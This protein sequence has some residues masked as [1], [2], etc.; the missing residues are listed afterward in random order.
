MYRRKQNKIK[1]KINQKEAYCYNNQNYQNYNYNYGSILSLIDL[2]IKEIYYMFLIIILKIYFNF[3]IKEFSHQGYLSFFSLDII[4]NGGAIY[5]IISSLIKFYDLYSPFNQEWSYLYIWVICSIQLLYF[6][7]SF[8]LFVIKLIYIK[9]YFIAKFRILFIILCIVAIIFNFSSL[10]DLNHDKYSFQIQNYEIKKLA[11]YKNYFKRHYVNLYLSKDYDVDEYELCFEMK[12]PK[13]F[14][15]MFTN[16]SPYSLWEFEQKKDYFIGCRNV[17]FK[18]N[19]SIDKNNPLSFFKCDTNEK[20]INVLPNYCIS[21]EQR[22]KKHNF[23]Y[24]LNIFEIIV[25]FGCFIYSKLANY[26]FHNHYFGNSVNTYQEKENSQV[27]EEDDEDNENEG[28]GEEEEDDEEYEEDEEEE[29]EEEEEI[30]EKIV[31]KNKYRKISKKKMKYYKKKQKNRFRKNIINNNKNENEN[32]L[33]QEKEKND[34][35]EDNGDNQEDEKTNLL[36][37]NNNN[38]TSNEN[39]NNKNDKKDDDKKD[40][41]DKNDDQKENDKN[42]E[43]KENNRNEEN[44]SENENE[45]EVVNKDEDNNNNNIIKKSYKKN[46]FIYQLFLSGIVDRIKNKFYNV[47]KEIDKEIKEDE[48]N[49]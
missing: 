42:K 34:I 29:E 30:E 22:R 4:C 3:K 32:N 39:S 16:E 23:I 43:N 26:I 21:A 20:K 41:N 2:I 7:T 14:S 17:S 48:Q 12:Y 33:I 31:R 49:Y 1:K 24:H 6:F 47:L 44:D 36:E 28:E 46:N 8:F 38:T 18:D 27:E 11:N 25:F 35:K 15:E 45:S 19:P 9:I 5:Y 13:N 10:N 37:D 40:K